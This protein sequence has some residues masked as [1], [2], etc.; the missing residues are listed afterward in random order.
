MQDA[1]E[2]FRLVHTTTL[3][4]S[5]QALTV[6]FHLT[7]HR[8]ELAD[9]YYQSLYRKLTDNQLR[10][11]SRGAPLLSLVFRSMSADK[12]EDRLAAYCLRLLQIAAWHPDPAFIIGIL[13][14]ISKCTNELKMEPIYHSNKLPFARV[15]IE[16]SNA[17]KA[18]AYGH[19]DD[20]EERFI[21]VHSEDEEINLGEVKPSLHTSSWFHRDLRLTQGLHLRGKSTLPSDQT[22]AKSRSYKTPALDPPPAWDAYQPSGREPRFSKALGSLAWCLFLLANHYHPT[23]SLLARNLLKGSSTSLSPLGGY[24]GDPFEDFSLARFLDR[25]VCRTPKQQNQQSTASHDR[26]DNVSGDLMFS[27]H[28]EEEDKKKTKSKGTVYDEDE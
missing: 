7:Q 9:R 14:L 20:E 13:V 17:L 25:F 22:S 3:S 27:D 5:I 28:S 21:D 4:T 18:D 12:D 2:I 26:D 10:W 19:D 23:V 24:T 1:N 16:E 11:S 6:L 15:K 8:P